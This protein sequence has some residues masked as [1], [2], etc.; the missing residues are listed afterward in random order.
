MDKNTTFYPKNMSSQDSQDQ[1]PHK[2]RRVQS[3]DSSRTDIFTVSS[4]ISSVSHKSVIVKKG[5]K[6]SSRVDQLLKEINDE[7]SV[8]V[9]SQG[10]GIQK[11]ITL[12]EI[13]KSKLDKEHEQFNKLDSYETLMKQ[14]EI[15]D[16]KRKVSVFYTLIRKKEE[17]VPDDL[18]NWTRQVLD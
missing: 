12:L 11:M 1:P 17:A 7:G 4:S 18:K 13:V 10:D 14:N 9:M 16:K 6:I 3:Q 8:L 2:K 5:D 15:L